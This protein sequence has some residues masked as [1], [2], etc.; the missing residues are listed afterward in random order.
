[1]PYRE[2]M[3]NRAFSEDILDSFLS[4][5]DIDAKIHQAF[6]ISNGETRL[7]EKHALRPGATQVMEFSSNSNVICY[8][9]L[10]SRTGFVMWLAV[11]TP[12]HL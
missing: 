4:V 1:M 2:N 11:A 9:S 3:E 6:S 8:G 7:T 5:E 10:C 12:I